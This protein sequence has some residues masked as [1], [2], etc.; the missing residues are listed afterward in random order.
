MV[1]E[2]APK[3]AIWSAV[4]GG[5]TALPHVGQPHKTVGADVVAV[6]SASQITLPQD[7]QLPT[8]R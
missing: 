8:S 7:T 5:N 1:A 2:S 6:V 4:N 3:L